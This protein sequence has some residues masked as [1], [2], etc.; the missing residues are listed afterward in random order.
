MEQSVA[1]RPGMV[2]TVEPGIYIP[3]ENLGVRIEDDVLVTQKGAKVLSG[4]IPKE[5]AEVERWIAKGG[6]IGR[7]RRE[8]EKQRLDR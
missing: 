7:I 3:A 5:T 4:W 1:L 8:I 6:G 2:L